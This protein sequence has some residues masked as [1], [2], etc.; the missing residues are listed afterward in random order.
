LEVFTGTTMCST[1][2]AHRAV[3]GGYNRAMTLRPSDPQLINLP[4]VVVEVESVFAR[5]EA[6]LLANEVEVLI[7][8]FWD[9]PRVVRYGISEQHVGHRDI[10]AYRREQAIATPP[11]TLRNTVITTFGADI[12]TVDTEFVVNATGQVGRQ[13]QTWIRTAAGWRVSS[14]HVS[15][16]TGAGN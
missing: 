9:D 11:R 4:D 1:R 3:L 5:Y 14:A 10:A 8:L 12:A 16:V 15:W 7:E 2:S 6:A 13:S